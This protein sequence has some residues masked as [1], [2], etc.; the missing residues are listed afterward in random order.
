MVLSE[1]HLGPR[2][3]IRHKYNRSF[4]ESERRNVQIGK[5]LKMPHCRSV[6][7]KL[8]PQEFYDWKDPTVQ[9]QQQ[10]N[11][12]QS[13]TFIH[14]LLPLHNCIIASNLPDLW[15]SCLL[16]GRRRSGPAFSIVATRKKVLGSDPSR[17][18]MF[19]LRFLP[20]SELPST[21][22]LFSFINSKNHLGQLIQT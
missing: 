21:E 5:T 2:P 8:R 17:V 12:T 14:L 20:A 22:L 15:S 18:F 7:R 4:A 10:F 13:V 3:K 19:P 11:S 1:H 9:L 16:S 6:N